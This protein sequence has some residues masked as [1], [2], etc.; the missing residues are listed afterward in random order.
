MLEVLHSILIR[1]RVGELVLD[2]LKEVVC[3]NRYS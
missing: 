3:I 2:L 1:I